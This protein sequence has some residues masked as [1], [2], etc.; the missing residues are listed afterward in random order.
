LFDEPDY[1]FTAISSE[2]NSEPTLAQEREHRIATQLV[3]LGE[4]N[5]ELPHLG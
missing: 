4:E 3:I 5:R 1:R 2:Q